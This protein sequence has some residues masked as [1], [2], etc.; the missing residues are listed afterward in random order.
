MRRAFTLAEVLVVL[1]IL[2]LLLALLLPAVQS[3]RSAAARARCANN[4]KQ[5]ALAVHG[6]ESVHGRLPHGGYQG[7]CDGVG[8][9]LWQVA[10]YAEVPA[11]S[12][13]APS[14]VFCPARRAPVARVHF[15][16]RGL[17]DY[18]ALVPG[19]TGGWVEEGRAGRRL[20]DLPRGASRTAMMTEKRLAPSY[21]D[22]PQDDQGWSNGG[23]D[24]DVIVYTRLPPLRDAADADPWGYRAGSA[25]AAGLNVAMCDGSV[26]F[27]LYGIDSAVWLGIGGSVP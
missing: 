22:V 24:N 20:T 4:L 5:L 21:G 1:A 17:C 25:H 3:A 11:D 10:P 12:A 18:A 16:L 2:A 13:A 27:I 14:V 6:Y 7:E 26:V 8:G 23:F 9:W 15:V 19:P